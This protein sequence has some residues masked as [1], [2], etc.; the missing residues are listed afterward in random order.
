MTSVPNVLLT[1]IVHDKN[2]STWEAHI[3][4]A[5]NLDLDEA[6]D[7]LEKT[8]NQYASELG[9][10]WNRRLEDAHDPIDPHGAVLGATV[11]IYFHTF[12]DFVHSGKYWLRADIHRRKNH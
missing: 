4:I 3:A 7:L 6:G 8:A 12:T 11:G 10:S 1:K 2:H 9:S 5:R